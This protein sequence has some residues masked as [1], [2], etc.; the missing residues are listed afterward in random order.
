MT[1]S[2]RIGYTVILCAVS[3]GGNWLWGG[4]PQ[5]DRDVWGGIAPHSAVVNPVLEP[6][7][8]RVI[9]L[10][11]EWEF[12]RQPMGAPWRNGIWRQFYAE[13]WKPSHTL[14]VPGCWEA[15]GVG[16][17]GMSESW[18]CKW[19]D[20]PKPIRHIYKGD[21]WYRKTVQIPDD[22]NGSRIWLKIGG[23]RS[24]GWF[25]VNGHAVAW[26]DSYC[27][28]YKYEITPFVEAGKT[29]TV[30]AQVNNALPSRKGLLSA[31]HRWGGIYRDIE[32]EATPHT[33]IDDAWARGIFD[34]QAA[35]FHVT[36][37]SDGREGVSRV[38]RVNV[39]GA[40]V[41]R[42]AVGGE[43]VLRVP[44]RNFRPWSPERPNLYTGIIEIAE[45]G[46]VIHTRRERFGVRKLEVRGKAFYLNGKPFFVRGFGDDHVYPFT[47][48]TLGDRALHRAHLSQARAAGFN[49]VRLHTHCE[50]PE[51]FEAA[52]ELGILIQPELPYYSDVPTE[53][54]AFDPK[55][56]VTELYRHFRR[57]PSF[58]VYSM[59]NEGS[60]GHPLDA[61]LHAYVKA[62]DPD[63]LKINQDCHVEAINPPDCADYLG[64]PINP[65]PRGSVDPG[66]P[67]VTHEYLN[68][69]V[70]CDSRDEARYTGVWEPPVTRQSRAEWLAAFGLDHTWGDRLQDA[71]HALQRHY[72]KQGIEAARA[73][74]YCDGYIFWTIVDVVVAQRGTYTAQGLFNPFWEPK[75]NG[76]SP[77]AFA[78]FNGPSCILLDLP[79]TKR[80]FASGD[81]L[82]A[83]LLFTHFG[84]ATL[85]NA[86][87][88]WS[89]TLGEGTVPVR[90]RLQIGEIPLGPARKVATADITFP[91]VEKPVPATLTASLGA[92][93]NRWDL[94]VF[95]KRAKRDGSAIAVAS[96]FR[97][98]LE[99]R[100]ERLLPEADAGKA[101]IVI[102][103]YG[104]RMAADA[105][106]RGQRVITLSGERGE[107]NVSLGWWSMGP[108]VGAALAD[109]PALAALPHEGVLS[110]LLFRLVLRGGRALPY[111]GLAQEDLL[112]VG[113]GGDRCY[114]YLA[115]AKIGNGSAVM[116]FGLNLLAETPEAAALLDGLIDYAASD[117]FAPAS[118][119]EMACPVPQNGWGRTIRAGDTATERKDVPE[120]YSRMSVAR[121]CKGQT[122][123]V[124]ET[125]P[126][127]ETVSESPVFTFTFP[128]GMGYPQQ[129]PASF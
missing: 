120:G 119:V 1:R 44:L 39:D 114:L 75:R 14:R 68:L 21:G 73:D 47:G 36:V 94:W 74:P 71:Q 10:R 123:L 24:Q 55:R 16:E 99:Q 125:L 96:R 70:K 43:N 100:Y 81:R 51:Y 93:S 31:M 48:I 3:A 90:N 15:Q 65:W 66:R 102:A 98:A 42:D 52:D 49:F 62:M 11:G 12:L 57:H 105:L 33:F 112:M 92:V 95:P 115:Q 126:V 116:A 117:R 28:S 108:Q 128:G 84:D 86:T 80:V 50:V 20:N 18:D 25:W 32:L 53:S 77:A 101:R 2:I 104:S 111:P 83:D 63:R 127:P 69:C 19:D 113:E 76:S 8:G 35:E 85:T 118:R 41:E 27:G 122:E 7:A 6:E 37:D 5:P 59:G 79:D 97:P 23:V 64:G 109:H 110:P 45:N 87:I 129:P 91:D 56:D 17:P 30:V 13:S 34:E 29:A 22:W 106:A 61:R 121:A 107:P 4:E 124:W 103:G 88:D 38:V 82:S 54:F 78:S 46:K 89:L 40:R 26:V 72:Q 9:S 58:A 67:F 60:F